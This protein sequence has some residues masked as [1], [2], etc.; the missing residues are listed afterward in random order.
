VIAAGFAGSSARVAERRSNA[1][2]AQGYA[3]ALPMPADELAALLADEAVK[4]AA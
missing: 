3:L 2:T 4:Q 1:A